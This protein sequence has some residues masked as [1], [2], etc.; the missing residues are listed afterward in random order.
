[1][2]DS[3]TKPQSALASPERRTEDAGCEAQGTGN[4]DAKVV[5]WHRELPPFDAEAIG[6]HTLEATSCRVA[7]TI[8]HRDELWH[9]CYNDLMAQTRVRLEQEVARLG[10]SF[11]H[12]LAEAID[13][14]HDDVKGEAW[15]HGR[16]DYV[17]Y[18]RSTLGEKR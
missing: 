17:L 14:R 16:F 9:R 10:G 7:G 3:L 5:Y 6:E 18:R 1:M 13:S 15:L 12:V 8:A 2:I 4:A 11:A